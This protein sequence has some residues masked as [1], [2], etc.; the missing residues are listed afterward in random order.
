MRVPPNAPGSLRCYRLRPAGWYRFQTT[1]RNW[2]IS[3]R[4]HSVSEPLRRFTA[5]LRRA[6]H[7][8]LGSLLLLPR[9]GDRVPGTSRARRMVGYNHPF[10]FLPWWFPG[11]PDTLLDYRPGSRYRLLSVQRVQA[12]S[13]SCSSRLQVPLADLCREDARGR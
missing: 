1:P 2:V 3:R 10:F 11:V 5:Q 13:L 4:V 12:G 6:A 7:L 8:L 9:V